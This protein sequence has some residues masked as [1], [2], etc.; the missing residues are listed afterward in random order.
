MLDVSRFP[1]K[2]HVYVLDVSR[3]PIK[4]H[5]CVRCVKVHYQETCMC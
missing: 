1:I 4:R 2:I 3:F 5:V